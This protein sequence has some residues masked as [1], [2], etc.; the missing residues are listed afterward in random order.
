MGA[1]K[2]VELRVVVVSKEVLNVCSLVNAVSLETV[3]TR[4]LAMFRKKVPLAL[5]H[6]YPIKFYQIFS[7]H[8]MNI[9]KKI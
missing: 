9:R 7:C 6:S 5:V 2:A 4:K 1:L 8:I 3:K